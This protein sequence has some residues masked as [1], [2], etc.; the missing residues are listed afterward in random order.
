[1]NKEQYLN[2]KLELK[3]LG[4]IL[5]SE[6]QFI[7]TCQREGRRSDFLNAHYSVINKKFDF[8]TKHIFMS[9]VRGKT[10][11]QIENNFLTK[12]VET[13]T[14]FELRCL[15]EKYG[16]EVDLNEKNQVFK[17]VPIVLSVE[18]VA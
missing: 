17:I 3:K 8:R 6:K 7:R 2:L 13:G 9:M 11:E 18:G 16:Y 14:E 4:G 12:V 1:M 5:K 15:C 10:R